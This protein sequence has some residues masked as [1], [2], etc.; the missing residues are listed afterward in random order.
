MPAL[1]NATNVAR[2]GALEVAKR[3]LLLQLEELGLPP[4]VANLNETHPLKFQFIEDSIDSTG[5][6][7][8]V[9][10]GHK[11][12]LITIN[13]AEADSAH[14]ELR[15]RCNCASHNAHD[16]A[17]CGTK[18]GIMSI[19]LGP[20]VWPQ[21]TIIVYSV[22]HWPSTMLRLWG[23]TTNTDHQPTGA[24]SPCQCLRDP[25]TLGKTLQR[26]STCTLIS[27]GHCHH[28]Q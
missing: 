14:R 3:R 23:R 13:L 4:F 16:S 6:P 22:I 12:G 11:D 28:R 27:C 5:R 21:R 19:G 17:T 8:R 9:T 2:W 1:S 24:Q 25:C 10:T 15:V 26:L 7:R 20:A 18:S